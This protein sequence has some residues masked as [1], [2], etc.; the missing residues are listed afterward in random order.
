MFHSM[1]TI[2]FQWNR[3]KLPGIFYAN[4]IFSKHM[5]FPKDFSYM[6]IHNCSLYPLVNPPPPPHASLPRD[7]RD[8]ARHSHALATPQ[9]PQ[10][11]PTKWSANNP[12]QATPYPF[13]SDSGRGIT[14]LGPGRTN[15]REAVS[16]VGPSANHF[17]A[18]V[19]SRHVN[20]GRA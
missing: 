3:Q 6:D 15:G 8:V 13:S 16:G 10:H 7:T 12:R 19:T 2:K 20:R 17:G 4:I 5:T 11:P 9:H 1:L 18:N 14:P